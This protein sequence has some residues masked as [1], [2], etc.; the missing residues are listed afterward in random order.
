MTNSSSARTAIVA[1]LVILL[2]VISVGGVLALVLI[3]NSPMHITWGEPA[4]PVP[5]PPLPVE[6]N[7]NPPVQ[8][9]PPVAVA[10]LPPAPTYTPRPTYT[11]EPTYTA[12]PTQIQEAMFTA[13]QPAFCRSGPS[14]VVWWDP[15]EALNK[16]QTVK[17]V[18][19]SSSE[20]GLWWYVEKTSGTRCWVYSE[21]GSTSGNVAGVPIKTAPNTPVPAFL[22]VT[23]KNKQVF[24]LCQV[25]VEP[26]GSGNWTELL[27]G[28]PLEPGQKM[29]F[30]A[31][32]GIYDIE[33]YDCFDNLIDWSYSFKI[34]PDSHNFS[35][36]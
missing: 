36:P 31:M 3:P 24:K 20:W 15:Q 28:L 27:T 29:H 26:A 10:T 18:G 13:N 1:L 22:D 6:V 19:K 2:C 30:N 35:T 4:M 5:A 23:L 12:E 14:D 21:L 9:A 7:P 32:P 34:N 11:L 17:I 8:Q 33:I 25:W 16:D